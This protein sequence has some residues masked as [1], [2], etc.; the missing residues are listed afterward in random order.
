ML[1]HRVVKLI[2][3]YLEDVDLLQKVVEISWYPGEGVQTLMVSGF[4]KYYQIA[5]CFRDQDLRADTQPEL[6]WLDMNLHSLPWK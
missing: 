1:R 2:R 6:T 5:R 3:R 4:D